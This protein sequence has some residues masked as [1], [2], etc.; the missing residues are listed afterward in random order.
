MK[1]REESEK[2]R[3]REKEEE[4]GKEE[5]GEARAPRSSVGVTS[6]LR[7]RAGVTG[8]HGHREGWREREE[9]DREEVREKEGGGTSGITEKE[10]ADWKKY[11]EAR[12]VE[13]EKMQSSQNLENLA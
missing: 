13:S 3:S 11:R 8:E 2:E 6:A 7:L 10:V 5:S 9:M 12:Q 4:D 1:T